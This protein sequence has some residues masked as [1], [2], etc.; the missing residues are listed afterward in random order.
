MKS[1][2]NCANNFNSK[3]MVV[4]RTVFVAT[5]QLEPDGE[6]NPATNPR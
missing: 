1:I 5:V 3:F 6:H 2:N 4:T